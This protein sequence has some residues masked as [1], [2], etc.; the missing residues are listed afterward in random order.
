LNQQGLTILLTT[1]DMDEADRL[2]ER[3]AIMDQGKILVNNTPAELK[4]M[5]PGGNALELRVR[6]PDPDDKSA[7]EGCEIARTLPGVSKVEQVVKPRRRK[8]QARR[9]IRTAR[10]SLGQ[11]RSTRGGR[12]PKT[13]LAS[14]P[15]DCTRRAPARWWAPPPSRSSPPARKCAICT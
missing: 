8:R 11:I 15:T 10:R 3:V 1:H 14:L 13:N 9:T 5:I 7:Q 2:C 12:L 6:V 4:K